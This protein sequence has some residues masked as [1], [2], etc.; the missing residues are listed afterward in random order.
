[1]SNKHN[2]KEKKDEISDINE[3]EFLNLI[4]N[5]QLILEREQ[6][7][8]SNIEKKLLNK[9]SINTSKS[10]ML[11]QTLNV[12]SKHLD[13]L[14][15]KL[16]KIENTLFK[17]EGVNHPVIDSL[18]AQI[19]TLELEREML[20]EHIQKLEEGVM[21]RE[22]AIEVLEEWIKTFEAER[23]RMID[24][25][26]IFRE[27]VEQW[28]ALLEYT[29]VVS[30]SDKRYHILKVLTMMGEPI[31]RSQLEAHIPGSSI[32]IDNAINDLLAINLIS[33]NEKGDVI[34]TDPEKTQWLLT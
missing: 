16:S 5:I 15:K 22:I 34:L 7:L 30:Q 20:I 4:S 29:E 19:E 11:K 14:E 12:L 2:K 23:Q 25:I 3:E 18:E 28:Q 31:N 8:R 27:K 17:K 24:D 9:I 32:E 21:N 13:S 1:M 10:I 26:V 6:K 33:I